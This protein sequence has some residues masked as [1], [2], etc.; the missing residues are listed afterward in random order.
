MIITD[1]GLRG[2]FSFENVLQVTVLYKTII[3][4]ENPLGTKT[5]TKLSLRKDVNFQ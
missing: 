2:K 1:E 4:E 3:T 5:F